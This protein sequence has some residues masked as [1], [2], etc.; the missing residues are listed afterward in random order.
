MFFAKVCHSNFCVR[1]YYFGGAQLDPMGDGDYCSLGN[2]RPIQSNSNELSEASEEQPPTV[3][4]KTCL[5]LENPSL[6]YLLPGKV[7]STALPSSNPSFE[8]FFTDGFGSGRAAVVTW[9][10]LETGGHCTVDGHKRKLSPSDYT[11]L[12]L[13]FSSFP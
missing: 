8:D 2:L 1:L 11:S 10:I 6:D 7:F 4:T 9:L 12:C 13:V 5:S 3:E